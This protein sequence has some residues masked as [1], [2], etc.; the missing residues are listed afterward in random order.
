MNLLVLSTWFPYPPDNG[1][2]IRARYLVKALSAAHQV[3]VVAFCP[4]GTVR[5]SGLAQSDRVRVHA[6]PAD[7]FQH[8]TQ[9]AWVKFASPRPVIYWPNRAMQRA[10]QE[11]ATT[12]RW[13]AVVAIQGPAAPY[14][15]QFKHLPRILDVDTALSFQMHA[16]HSD[17]VSPIRSPR[18]WLSWKK[19]HLYER[20]LFRKFHVCCVA[21]AM[22]TAYARTLVQGTK[23]RVEV[24]A[25]GVD[26][27]HNQPY[28]GPVRPDSLIYSGA[29]TYSAN[30]DAVQFF[31]AD[32]YPQIKREVPTVSLTV[33]GSTKGVDTTGLQLD[34]SVCLTG[35]IEDMR[36]AVGGSTICVVPIRQ[37]SGTRLK[38]LEAMAL[39]TPVVSTTKGAEGIEARHGE[40]LLLADDAAN[41]ADCTLSLLR[42]VDL[43]RRLAVNARRLVEEH[44][45]W[46]RIGERF[47]RLVEDVVAGR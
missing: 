5:H 13:E 45:D 4:P 28:V 17:Q 9:P 40:H 8:V 18:T 3:T 37:G 42:D 32:I 16:R 21:G 12:T 41:F 11:V 30:F 27:H 43:R 7:P 2:K 39:G 29:L 26:C 46:M 14:A 47:T 19:A 35:Y 34:N 33:T 20:A 10:L 25:N 23:C 6:V 38:I 44:Y 36:P 31:L 24:V 15:L 22:E 1:S